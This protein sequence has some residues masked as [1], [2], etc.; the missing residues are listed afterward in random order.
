[1]KMCRMLL[2][3]AKLTNVDA[4]NIDWLITSGILP[5]LRYDRILL[6]PSAKPGWYPRLNP[7]AQV[8]FLLYRTEKLS[9]SD[10]IMKYV[11][12]FKGEEASLL[13][14]CGEE[15]FKMAMDLASSI[16]TPRYKLCF[17]KDATK[18]DADALKNALSNLDQTIKGPYFM[19][20][21]LSLA[22]LAVFPF[23]NAWEFVMGR[24]LQM[25]DA[26]G[27]NVDAIASQ[28]PRVLEYRQLMS[29]EPCVEQNAFQ[30]EEFI[31]F[32]DDIV[33]KKAAAA[34]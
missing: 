20:E 18:E 9:D 7:S 11:D 25:D 30:E 31:K 19:G 33:N 15:G 23:L 4:K 34:L 14:K 2:A 6:D 1:M 24:L 27:D 5:P 3:N 13:S 28:W 22:D 29:K 12:L 32:V 10:V 17:T 21:T 8:P 16:A 26:S